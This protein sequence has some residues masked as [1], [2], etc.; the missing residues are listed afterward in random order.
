MDAV[1]S[2]KGYPGG[3]LFERLRGDQLVYYAH[4][5]SEPGLEPGHF[6]IMAATAPEL[7]E[8]ALATIREVVTQFRAAPPTPEALERGRRMC[9]AEHD[10]GLQELSARATTAALDEL[11]GLGYDYS[12]HYAEGISAVTAEDVLREAGELLDLDRCVTVVVG[13]EQ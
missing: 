10:L 12:D 8:K 9:I 5:W 13:P 1:L 7:A 11:Y 2:G 4:A 6:A 3:V